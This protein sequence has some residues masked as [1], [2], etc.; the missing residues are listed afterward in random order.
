MFIWEGARGPKVKV[1]GGE[2]GLAGLG[3]EEYLVFVGGRVGEVA[4]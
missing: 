3:V 2:G 1:D 4:V